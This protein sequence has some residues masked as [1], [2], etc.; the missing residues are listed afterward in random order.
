MCVNSL[1]AQD[2]LVYGSSNECLWDWG[3]SAERYW[4]CGKQ[5]SDSCAGNQR[6]SGEV[7]AG[8]F[9][10]R[11]TPGKLDNFQYD[12]GRKFV[13]CNGYDD[14]DH[15]NAGR[16]VD[17]TESGYEQYAINT[18]YNCQRIVNPCYNN[19]WTGKQYIIE[20]CDEPY[21]AKCLNDGTIQRKIF[22]IANHEQKISRCVA[23]CSFEQAYDSY[24]SD[25]CVSCEASIRQGIDSYGTCVKCASNETFANRKYNDRDCAGTECCGK[26]SE[27]PSVPKDALKAC[28]RCPAN[29]ELWR[30]CIE[31][32]LEGDDFKKCGF[33]SGTQIPSEYQLKIGTN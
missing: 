26:K 16:W 10:S 14:K 21:E 12:D 1:Y 6:V 31:G 22:D 28:W 23:P 8:R 5:S 15:I 30:R 19:G 7:V 4:F 33:Q 2:T 25:E 9:Y 3:G 24:N 32:K 27:T 13:C 11:G 17:F 20:E 18:K 29:K